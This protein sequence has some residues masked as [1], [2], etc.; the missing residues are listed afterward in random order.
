ML[1]QGLAFLA[2]LSSGQPVPHHLIRSWVQT[3]G[4]RPGPGPPHSAPRGHT[5][6][7]QALRGPLDQCPQ[8][9]TRDRPLLTSAPH[10]PRCLGPQG[11][12]MGQGIQ[13]I[14]PGGINSDASKCRT[15]IPHI[16]GEGLPSQDQGIALLGATSLFKGDSWGWKATGP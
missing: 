9:T 8:F 4:G 6:R 11:E 3:P 13:L 16:L 7:P 1:I 12:L 5:P 2:R 10:S 14:P 15:Q